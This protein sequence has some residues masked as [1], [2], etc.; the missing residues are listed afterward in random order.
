MAEPFK[1][2]INAASIGAVGDAVLRAW[3]AFDR[4]AFVA[5]ATDG[6]AALELKG[7]VQHVA[8]ALR[9]ALP[10][11]AGEAIS[12]LVA[13]LPPALPDEREV[14]SGF[15]LWPVL[16]VVEDHAA[17]P[18]L[19]LPALREM[20]RRFSAEFAVRPYIDRFPEAAWPV[21]H[22]WAADD[23]VHVRRLASEGSRSR[24]P[25]GRR[26]QA[27]VADP[28]RG[29]ELITR[30]VDDPSPYVRRSVANHLGDVA[31]DHPE[32]AVATGAAWMA[33]RAD[34]RPLVQ[35]GLRTLLKAGHPG[36]L[37]LFGHDGDVVASDLAVTPEQ[38][39]VGESVELT[40]TLTGH[41]TAR[42]DVIWRWPGNRGWSSRTFR[43]GLRE[44]DGAPWAFRYRL[45]LKPVTTRP[46]RPGRHELALR[47]NG[48]ET[49]AVGFEVV[50]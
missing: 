40:A 13:S 26:I 33:E 27:S 41:G 23:D 12:V 43:G 17:D 45:S 4:A 14:S 50:A 34:R 19:A 37:A 29:L 10:A 8:K 16:Q 31:K 18:H 20:T 22:A 2:L 25:W 24:L 9:A 38:A 32:R 48:V 5:A 39:A 47:V 42:V 21:L 44:L 46:T 28:T 30:L 35:H 1:E 6:L 11:D 36:A 15:A 49:A 7:R 3:P